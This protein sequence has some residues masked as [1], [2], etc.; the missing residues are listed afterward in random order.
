MHANESFVVFDIE[1]DRTT[2]CHRYIE[3]RITWVVNAK[4]WNGKAYYVTASKVDEKHF[5]EVFAGSR[6]SWSFYRSLG[7]TDK[8]GHLAIFHNDGSAAFYGTSL[9]FPD[10]ELSL[11]AADDSLTIISA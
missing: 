2:Y 5:A 7:G 8:G 1:I 4:V 11:I 9:I 10:E 3:I 6:V